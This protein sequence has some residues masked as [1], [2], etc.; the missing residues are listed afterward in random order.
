MMPLEAPE[1]LF[2]SRMPGNGFISVTPKS[3]FWGVSR[4]FTVYM[5]DAQHQVVVE[6]K[7]YP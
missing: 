4:V 1:A 3:L 5:S 7:H 6:R 2:V